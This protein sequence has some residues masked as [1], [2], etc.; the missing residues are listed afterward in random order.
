MSRD[1]SVVMSPTAYDVVQPKPKLTMTT[2]NQKAAKL[3]EML[4]ANQGDDVEELQLITPG[5][6]AFLKASRKMTTALVDN[7]K[8][9]KAIDQEK[10][11][12]VSDIL[13]FKVVSRGAINDNL[14]SFAATG[15][16]TLYAQQYNRKKLPF[17]TI[18]SI[19]EMMVML[20]NHFN[21]DPLEALEDNSREDLV[22]AF[23]FYLVEEV[24]RYE[25]DHVMDVD[26]KEAWSE[27]GLARGRLFNNPLYYHDQWMV[28]YNDEVHTIAPLIKDY[29]MALNYR[30]RMTNLSN[31]IG[32]ADNKTQDLVQA[33]ANIQL[34][35]V[36]NIKVDQQINL[37][38]DV[39][40]QQGDDEDMY[41]EAQ[42]LNATALFDD[43]DQAGESTS[44]RVCRPDVLTLAKLLSDVDV[45][46]PE[47]KP[48]RRRTKKPDSKPN[49][50]PPTPT[51]GKGAYYA[52][53]FAAKGKRRRDTETDLESDS[54]SDSDSDSDSESYHTAQNGRKRSRQVVD[55]PT[56]FL[57]DCLDGLVSE[58]CS[59]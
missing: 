56:S 7:I 35:A 26:F 55:D 3:L 30:I 32:D 45:T 58:L 38:K 39:A 25:L 52:T 4:Q 40:N 14:K 10:D 20:Y 28:F 44:A 5:V 37:L 48:I 33:S 29:D 19:M 42:R 54:G 31:K 49:S 1:H 59:V 41:A 22:K 2:T 17:I 8:N 34:A 11:D 9:F 23:E 21:V 43:I 15:A 13:K 18:T 27:A 6:D 51:R 50:Q 36:D 12:V 16:F 46:L 47:P 24:K 57:G 53:A